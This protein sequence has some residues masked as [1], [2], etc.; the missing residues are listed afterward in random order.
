M[1]IS[2]GSILSPQ[3]HST[4][5]RDVPR[6]KEVDE[7]LKCFPTFTNLEPPVTNMNDLFPATQRIP[8]EVDSDP[9]KASSLKSLLVLQT[10]YRGGHVYKRI[11]GYIDN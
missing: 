1:V 6:W 3:P 2:G 9:N 10:V 5:I 7:L 11:F 8:V 4:V